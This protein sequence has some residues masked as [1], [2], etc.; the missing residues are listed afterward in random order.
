M[1]DAFEVDGLRSLGHRT[2]FV[3]SVPVP[4]LVLGS[5]QD[6][7]IVDA[8]ARE[9]RGVALIRRRSGGGAVLL[10]PGTVVWL[11]TWVPGRDPLWQDDVARSR[12]WV[13]EWWKA[14]LGGAAA[15]HR[16]VP[17]TNRW[18]RS[19]CFAGLDSGEVTRGGRKVVGVAQW[20]GREGALTHSL[21]YRAVDWSTIA[22]LLGLEPGAAAALDEVAAPLEPGAAGQTD[23]IDRLLG[24]LPDGPTWEV[25]RSP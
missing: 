17:V 2:V 3:R 12:L 15:V 19:V 8:A 10:G 5:T 6:R 11:D 1:A 25:R 18:S 21:A 16:G 14:A 9:R 20:R 24:S 4:T 22:E 7:S 13:G 23:L